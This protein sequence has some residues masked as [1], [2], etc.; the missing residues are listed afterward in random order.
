MRFRDTVRVVRTPCVGASSLIG[1]L[2]NRMAST[3]RRHVRF[4]TGTVGRFFLGS[5]WVV[6]NLTKTHLRFRDVVWIGR[7]LDVVLQRLDGLLVDGLLGAQRCHVARVTGTGLRLRLRCHRVVL[8]RT[9]PNL[10]LSDSMWVI[11]TLLVRVGM[12]KGDFL[13]RLTHT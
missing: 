8:N 12:V 11:V 9:Q 1:N 3:S 10:C 13:N 6:L 7:I 2:F 5:Q 4:V